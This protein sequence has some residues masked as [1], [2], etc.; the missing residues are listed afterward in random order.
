MTNVASPTAASV[1]AD[2]LL[3]VIRERPDRGLPALGGERRVSAWPDDGADAATLI[4]AAD[5]AMYAAKRAGN[6]G[7]RRERRRAE[8]GRPADPA[9][10]AGR[11]A[12]DG[13]LT[14][15]YQPQLTRHRSHHRLRGAHP[16]EPPEA[17]VVT[18]RPLH[19][20]RRAHRPDGPADRVRR[21][22]SRRVTCAVAAR[23]PRVQ[24]ASTCR[25]KTCTTSTSPN[26]SPA[27]WP[28]RASRPGTGDRDHRERRA[29]PPRPRRARPADLSQAGVRITIDDFGTGFSSLANLRQL[30]VQRIKIDRSSSRHGDRRTTRWSSPWSTS[31]TSSASPRSPR[32]SSRRLG[33]PRATR[34]RL[35][36]DSDRQGASDRRARPVLRRRSA[37]ISASADDPVRPP[38][39]AQAMA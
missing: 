16:L 21:S 7:S 5:L 20:A 13:E 3:A 29:R 30:P 28:S 17:R 33:P 24:V 4:Q 34:L 22:A 19:A 26:S 25:R 31:P 6:L 39:A 35:G 10:R 9:G 37:C 2:R 14:V 23:R 27:R 1:R 18:A 15:A 32:A 36:R 38:V 11:R 8:R 12:R